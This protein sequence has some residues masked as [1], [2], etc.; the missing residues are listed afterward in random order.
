[1][2]TESAAP[3]PALVL[4]DD[5]GPVAVL[6]LN[7][8]A[9]LNALNAELLVA[10]LDRLTALAPD[11]SIRAVVVTGAGEKAFVA[12]ADIA[13]MQAM[14]PDEALAFARAGGA[15]ARRI[16]QMP[17][18]VIAAVNGFALGG[19]CELALACDIVLASAKAKLGLPEV[20][21][22][23][24]PGFGGTQRLL[25]IIGV[26]AARRW[27]LSGDVFGADEALRYGVVQELHAPEE[28]LAKAI[29]LGRRIA[30]RGPLAVAAAKRV[31]AQGADQSLDA[32]IDAEARAFADCF[33]TADQREGMAAF[34]AKRPA[35]FMGQ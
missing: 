24:I 2:T 7:R 22:G 1:M 31:I 35:V 32:A 21:L 5:H 30:T 17:Q 15:V 26:H 33:A 28:L 23:V 8:P 12:G 6:T 4:R 16:A 9:A 29:D 13:A 10:L 20:T 25:R 3:A 18:V 27:V 11:P 19:G 34:L 14:A